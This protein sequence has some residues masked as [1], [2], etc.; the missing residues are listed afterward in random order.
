[1]GKLRSL[2]ETYTPHTTLRPIYTHLHPASLPSTCTLALPTKSSFSYHPPTKELPQPPAQPEEENPI[3]ALDLTPNHVVTAHRSGHVTVHGE[4]TNTI[5]PFHDERV[6]SFVVHDRTYSYVALATT[7]GA[8][9]IYNS[10]G[11]RLTHVLEVPGAVTCI[12]FSPSGEQLLVG[13]EDGNIVIFDLLKKDSRPTAE[14]AVH[15]SR[16]TG[17]EFVSHGFVSVGGD[18]MVAV[19]PLKGLVFGEKKLIHA[20]EAL[21]GVVA[22][23][24]VCFTVGEKC[25]LRAWNVR[26]GIEI[27]DRAMKLPFATPGVEED[28][29][30]SDRVTVIDIRVNGPR[31]MV[32]SLSDQ[33]L[34]FV[35]MA[36]DGALFLDDE[37][38]CGNL[39]EIYD[40]AR[41]CSSDDSHDYALATN[42]S[43][44]WVMTFNA[45]N[46]VPIPPDEPEENHGSWTCRAGLPGHDGIILSL[47]A[48]NGLLA[49]GARD[50]TARI[51]E[52]EEGKWGCVAVAEGHADAV[53]A[54][55]LSPKTEKFLVTG[56]A[57]KMLKL[58]PITGRKRLSA[59][60]TLLAHEKDINAVSISP[61]GKIIASGSQD[62]SLK[63]WGVDGKLRVKCTGHK[64][65]IW[66]VSF[67]PV[68]RIVASASGDSTVRIWSLD[69]Q[70]LRTLQGHISG[71]LRAVF[72]NSGAQLITSGADGLIKVWLTR[73]GE[74]GNTVDAHDDRIWALDEVNDGSVLIS[75]AA[76]GRV[77][78]WTDAT[79]IVKENERKRE[80][81]M[82]VM[83]QAVADAT[84]QRNWSVAMRGALELGLTQRI[85]DIVCEMISSDVDMDGTVREMLK[86]KKCNEKEKW[87]L[88]RKLLLCCREWVS[89]G[90][91][92]SAAIA[93]YVL[94][95]I[96]AT[97]G[98]E[99]IVDGIG[100]DAELVSVLAKQFDR[101]YRRIGELEVRC[102]LFEHTL[103]MMRGLGEIDT[104]VVE[105]E[106]RKDETVANGD[107]EMKPV[108]EE[109]KVVQEGVGQ[110]DEEKGEKEDKEKGGMED[111][112]KIEEI[113]E[114]KKDEKMLEIDDEENDRK[115]AN[116]KA[117]AAVERKKKDVV[118]VKSKGVKRKRTRVA[119]DVHG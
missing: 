41:V 2:R 102:A 31:R 8:V 86:V 63:L 90:G 53:T 5:R 89:A 111:E 60:W 64:R 58:W 62:R 99:E 4:T 39:E 20:G 118:A 81:E 14:S 107:V 112:E 75:G 73:S 50:R 104:R 80:E 71:V 88:V 11:K 57:D 47:D 38:L 9:R 55:A 52:Q 46:M 103:S 119:V 10:A 26:K 105:P 77:R 82:I 42:S 25:L 13:C 113:D 74:C 17:I 84:R 32:I 68:D 65:G 91:G 115:K 56:S 54:V 34:L 24:N 3:T 67:S 108:S 92:R 44:L 18:G 76:D 66:S 85:S 33:T 98:V 19:V 83:G 23:D 30:E 22:M 28:D 109:D 7:D 114:E 96:L 97:W 110:E 116:A 6:V 29:D 59:R 43:T 49:S 37:V 36:E 61:D 45:P 16:V 15:V 51:W 95:G 70:C 1:M 117:E 69:G 12:T 94:N 87:R 93:S 100:A 106:E 78:V 40:L 79:E 72:V 27:A 35:N 101:H 48:E 21:V